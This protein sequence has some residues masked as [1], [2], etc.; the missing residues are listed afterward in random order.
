[1]RK[2]LILALLLIFALPSLSQTP[3]WFPGSLEE[4][5]QKATAENKLILID[6]FSY[7]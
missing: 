6:F 2:L 5:K 4:A 7:G 1:M 3:F